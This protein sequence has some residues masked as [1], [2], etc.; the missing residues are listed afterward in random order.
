[1]C[2]C[3]WTSIYNGHITNRSIGT[4]DCKHCKPQTLINHLILCLLPAAA[5]ALA[6]RLSLRSFP[7]VCRL[8]NRQLII[9][10]KF[11]S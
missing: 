1:M 11:K 4:G 9:I 5:A 7:F 2:V 6:T 10:Y 3:V 8:L